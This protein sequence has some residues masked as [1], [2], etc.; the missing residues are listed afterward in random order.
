MPQQLP[1]GKIDLHTTL[2]DTLLKAAR[3]KALMEGKRIGEVLTQLLTEYVAGIPKRAK[4]T[5]RKAVNTE[6]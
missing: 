4:K 6:V 1:N 3:V 5:H 2:D